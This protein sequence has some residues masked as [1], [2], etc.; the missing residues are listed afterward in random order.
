MLSGLILAAL[1][2][3]G[4]AKG[5]APAPMDTQEPTGTP[6]PAATLEIPTP[7]PYPP[8]SAWDLSKE[9]ALEQWQVEIVMKDL[10]K[11]WSLWQRPEGGLDCDAV[12]GI[13]SK[14]DPRTAEAIV[15]ECVAVHERGAFVFGPELEELEI[16][17]AKI[18]TKNEENNWP[19]GVSISLDTVT[20]WETEEINP[21]DGSSIRT[22]YGVR[23]VYHSYLIFERG[24][25]RVHSFLK[26]VEDE[27]F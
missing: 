20:S 1:M 23:A 8:G 21:F 27:D 24:A 13:A 25:W 2:L 18:W 10:A 15:G 5:V 7:T 22:L 12:V 26:Q 3:S 16:T 14:T 6:A 4:C 9:V 11:F 17:H 19:G